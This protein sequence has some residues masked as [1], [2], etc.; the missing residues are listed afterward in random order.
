MRRI[1]LSA[2]IVLAAGAFFVLAGGASNS[3]SSAGTYKIELDNAFGLVN[4]GDFKV[5]GVR[6]GKIQSIGLDQ[7]TYHALITVSVTEKGFGDFHADTFCQ[8]R[9]QSLIGEYFLECDPGRTGRLQG[10]VIPVTQTQST[11]PADLVQNIMRLPYRERF[12]ILINELGAAVASRS[13]DL[14]SALRRAVPALTQTDNLLNL[15]AND[16]HTIQQLN[17]NSDRVITALANN[18]TQV[19]RFITEANNAA[20]HTANQASSFQA[21]WRDLPGFLEELRPALAKLGAAADAQVPVLN[22][23]NASAGQLHRFFTDLVP[24]SRESL[25]ALQSLGQTS[26]KGIPA[27]QASLPLVRHLNQFA[28]ST[29]ELAQNLAIVLQDLDN[30]GRAVE[31][32]SQS[33]GG[34]GYTGLEALLQYVFNQSMSINAYNNYGHLLSVDAF[35][36]PTCSPYTTPQ[37]IASNPMKYRACYS[38]LGPNQPGIDTPDP[39]T[40]TC[41][42]PGGHPPGYPSA[43][44]TGCRGA[45]RNATATSAATASQPRTAAAR[46]APTNA[47]QTPGQSAL[48]NTGSTA[49]GTVQSTA[50]GGGSNQSQQLLNYLLRP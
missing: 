34:A 12:T 18:S 39:V 1:L 2:A 36:D 40:G 45:P 28:S 37:M 10:N 8:S 23:L 9:P 14:Q 20:T 22:N 32:N 21:S 44:S 5:A 42:D 16:S 27:V 25:P 13:D 24:F 26:V 33:P 29:P 17:V 4:G 35:F 47:Q 15:L 43:P 31:G 46:S 48:G 30:R 50:A 11:I 38:W 41:A 3:S 49:A 6:A 7:K 19:Q